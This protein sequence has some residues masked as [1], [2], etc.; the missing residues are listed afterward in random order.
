MSA[1]AWFTELRHDARSWI[2]RASLVARDNL[3]GDRVEAEKL[4]QKVFPAAPWRSPTALNESSRGG[5]YKPRQVVIGERVGQSVVRSLV[6]VFDGNRVYEVDCSGCGCIQLR[7]AVQINMA[8]RRGRSIE[9]PRCRAEAASGKSMAYVQIIRDRYL[10][11]GPL[12]TDLET[13]AICEL[14]RQDLVAEFGPALEP[15]DFVRPID[16]RMDPGWPPGSDDRSP[17]QGRQ[18]SRTQ[19]QDRDNKEGQAAVELMRAIESGDP[20]EIGEA[21]SVGSK[22]LSPI[23][24]AFVHEPEAVPPPGVVRVIRCYVC[25]QKFPYDMSRGT[26]SDKCAY[27]VRKKIDP[28]PIEAKIDAAIAKARKLSEEIFNPEEWRKHAAWIISELDKKAKDPAAGAEPPKQQPPLPP[29]LSSKRLQRDLATERARQEAARESKRAKQEAE[30]R[31]IE[32]REARDRE[33][34]ILERFQ[35]GSFRVRMPVCRC[36]DQAR[37]NPQT[38]FVL[39]DSETHSAECRKFRRHFPECWTVL[40]DKT[41]WRWKVQISRP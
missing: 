37:E 20:D 19:E 4:S 14:V 39:G 2:L 31:T 41:S 33:E 7:Q 1:H 40:E 6:G 30:R 23:D 18:Q 26:C 17:K 3:R 21:I 13:R 34:F 22:L 32:A 10:D 36:V 9:C 15:D 16:M 38:T 24:R 11:G 35:G 28:R 25:R 8:L 12:Y 5:R 29:S 27:K